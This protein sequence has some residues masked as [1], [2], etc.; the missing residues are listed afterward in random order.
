M[1]DLSSNAG[2]A[3]GDV[4]TRLLRSMYV[5]MLTM[6][7][8]EERLAELLECKEVRCPVHLCTGQEAVA[9]GVCAAL[10]QEDYVFSTHR[11]HGHYLAKGG[12]LKAMMAEV[13]G[14]RTGCSRGRGGS[15]HLIAPEVGFLGAAPIVSGTIPLAVGSALASKLRGEERVSVAFFGDG[16]TDEGVLGEVMNFAALHKLPVIFLCENNFF[17]TH[18][19]IVERRVKDDLYRIAEIYGMPGVRVDGND[20][21]PVYRAASEAVTRARGGEG[22]TFL[23]CLTYRWRGHVGPKL[24]LEVGLGRGEELP[25]WRKKDP[26]A[27]LREHLLAECGFSSEEIEG[28]SAQVEHE[29]DEAVVFA[30]ES[31]YPSEEEVM[32]YVFREDEGQGRNDARD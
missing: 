25:R 29:V 18:L 32:H 23:E 20:V 8:V 12:E 3:S 7:T 17:S 10:R 26:V 21:F 9:A 5:S 1:R 27:R 24:D 28:M 19:H 22:P 13:W 11:C 16:A 14:K 15:M 4:P 31:P 2:A 6:R 30:R